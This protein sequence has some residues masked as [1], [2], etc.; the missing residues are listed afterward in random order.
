MVRAL[1]SA[2]AVTDVVA[3]HA[4]QA[5]DA[6]RRL[7]CTVREA[8]EV[9]RLAAAQLVDD[10]DRRPET[11]R[12][13]VGAFLARVRLHAETLRQSRVTGP[14][15][16]TPALGAPAA[17]LQSAAQRAAVERGLDELG[18]EDRLALLAR[19][20]YDLTVHQT[21]VAL[22][23]DA[24]QSARTIALA[25][26]LLV[27]AV[28]GTAPISMAG[29]DIAVGDLGQLAD[30]SAPPGG[31]F[32]TLRRH[33]SGCAECAAVLAVQSRAT[34][35]LSALPVLALDDADRDA[36]ISDAWRQAAA[37]LP[38]EAAVQQELRE[39]SRARPIVAP[40]IATGALLG[41]LVLGG[42]LGALL[43]S[44]PAQGSTDTVVPTSSPPSPQA[45]S[46]SAAPVT[47]V[48]TPT[49]SVVTSTAVVSTAPPAPTT[50]RPTPSPSKTT[51][52][53][54]SA[55]GTP[56]GSTAAPSPH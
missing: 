32:A 41:A 25:R 34:A 52:P 30:G 36:L 15:D 42:G 44:H 21:A 9:T 38:A 2:S 33:V 49:P 43:A 4:D 39:G 53:S 11:V 10:L 28:E 35:M 3:A 27:A 5:G 12:D 55:S 47:T 23:L 6:A 51:S 19:D 13:L 18:D 54:P 1:V 22:S 29:H 20:S 40:L 8:A 16:R 24:P 56:T 26:L 7:G 48:A 14:T 17:V 50:T 31:R 46:T 37:V 45:G